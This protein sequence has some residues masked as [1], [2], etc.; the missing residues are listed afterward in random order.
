ML[1]SRRKEL[2]RIPATPKA[3]LQ[4]RRDQPFLLGNTPP[5]LNSK[6]GLRRVGGDVLKDGRELGSVRVSAINTAVAETR[7]SGYPPEVGMGEGWWTAWA[8][9]GR[10][11][12]RREK[13]A[14]HDRRPAWRRGGIFELHA[15]PGRT[16]KKDAKK[17][18]DGRRYRKIIALL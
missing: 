11:I 14:R 6:F 13:R 9:A 3:M 2:P 15:L 17:G 12:C 8:A 16:Q 5:P 18:L 4:R 1:T 7:I 10:R